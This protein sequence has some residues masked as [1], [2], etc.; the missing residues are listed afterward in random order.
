MEKTS[1]T[2]RWWDWASIGLLFLVLETLA[3]RLVATNWTPF[4]YLMQTATYLGYVVGTALGYSR[5]PR[6]VAQWLSLVYMV[7]MLPLQWTLMIDQKTSLEEQF[8]SVIGRLYFSTS[9]FLARRP[10]DDP[11][12]FVI[13]MT[14][15]FW[16]ISYWASY[17]LVRNQNYLEAV[18]PSAVGMLIIQNYDHASPGRLWFLA[19]FAFIALLLLGRIHFLQNKKSWRERRVFLSPDNSLELTSSMVIAAGLII[20]VSWTIPA[21]ISSWSSAVKT[22]NKFTQ[23]WRDFTES[24]D[25][26]VSALESP[27]GG[28]RGEFFGSELPLGHGFPLSDTIMFNVKAPDLASDQKPPR[29]YWR[30]R[31]Y[32]YYAKGQW[33]TTGTEREDYSPSVVNPFNVAVLENPPAHF[34]FNTG[35][36]TFSLLYSPAQPIWIS[37]EGMT[38]TEPMADTGKEIIAWHAY[39]A[40]RSGETY[41]VDAILTNPNIQQLGDAGTEYPSWVTKK[42]LQLPK[43]FS[44]RIRELAQE[45]TAGAKTPFEQAS[46]ITDYLRSNIEYAATVPNAP[47]NQDRLEWIL[48]DY[49][50]G[51]CVYYAS[52]EILM[53]RSLGIPARMAVGFAQGERSG[54]D[55]VVRRFHA[56]AWPEVYFPG[57]GWIE[58]EPTGNQPS[59]SRPLPPRDPNEILPFNPVG[60]V[61]PEDSAF[62]GR[63]QD[64]PGVTPVTPVDTRTSPLL[65]MIPLL[66][67]V[68][69]LTFFVNRRY[70]LATHIPMLVRASMERTGFEVPRWIYHWEY[71]GHLSPIER[72]F[73][74]VNFGL[75]TLDHA[76]PIHNTPIERARRLTSLLPQMSAQIKVLLDEHQT[77]LYTSR[78]ANDVQ[79]RRAAFD[80]RKEVITERIRYVLFGKP[81]RD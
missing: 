7:L 4:L 29:Y 37:R 17:A 60:N 77:S 33:Y 15:T 13:I 79:A 32:D 41:Q 55:Y 56:H 70:P 9:D 19:F 27:S 11:I 21:S 54:N 45:I 35:D 22:W 16:F 42:Y 52:A 47:R 1:A 30:G 14:F 20:L 26:A 46:L 57:I 63:A 5:F 38:F 8:A 10:V 78:I 76:M 28:K 73:E 51:Y 62:A 23:P 68:A 71:W 75:R 6:R 72:A 44:P 2:V 25:N 53:L 65:Y 66:I 50:K 40:L 49:K 64:D 59:L 43:E 69:F 39:P 12:F 61:R 74:S 3:S 80:I 24:M 36:A 58:F 81:M 67:A 31:T 34:V 18:L 48:F